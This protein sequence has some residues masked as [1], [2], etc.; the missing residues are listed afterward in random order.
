M[1]YIVVSIISN[2]DNGKFSKK[3]SPLLKK[4]FSF[5]KLKIEMKYIFNSGYFSVK[6]KYVVI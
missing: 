5:R 3:K 6:N 2:Y 1:R 4:L